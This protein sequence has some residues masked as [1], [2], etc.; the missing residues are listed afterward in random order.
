MPRVGARIGYDRA[1]LQMAH[2]LQHAAEA[3]R[4]AILEP[5]HRLRAQDFGVPAGG[6]LEI[7]AGHRDVGD[8]G[9]SGDAGIVQQP[10]R[11]LE[12][13]FFHRL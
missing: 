7:P 12:L 2:Q 11:R 1:A 6:L 8:V 5:A 13:G 3:E 9:P 10:L 4:H